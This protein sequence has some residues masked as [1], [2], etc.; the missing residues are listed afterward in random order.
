MAESASRRRSC[1]RHAVVTANEAPRHT[2]LSIQD[3][4]AAATQPLC[5]FDGDVQAVNGEFYR[6]ASLRHE[7]QEQHFDF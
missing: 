3:L 4:T 7:L 2:R 5:S 1:G 6:Y